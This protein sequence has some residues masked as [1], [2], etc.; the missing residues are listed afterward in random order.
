MA[1]K[2]EKFL[3]IELGRNGVDKYGRIQPRLP[4]KV[5]KGFILGQRAPEVLEG[6]VM[7]LDLLRTF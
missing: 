6:I 3:R 2:L 5:A 1:D 4:Y 7:N